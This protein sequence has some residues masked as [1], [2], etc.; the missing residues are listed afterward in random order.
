MPEWDSST[1]LSLR[2]LQGFGETSQSKLPDYMVPT[3][4]VTLDAFPL[5][6]NG[7]VNRRALP[8]PDS[9]RPD[10]DIQYIAPRTLT[11]ELL[12]KVWGEVLGVDEI[13]IHDSFFELGGHSLGAVQALVRIRATFGVEL[14]LQAFLRSS[15]LARLAE[16]VE[17]QMSE[18]EK[19]P[20]ALSLPKI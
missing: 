18:Q 8:A 16:A 11:E 5:T 3:H 1:L 9:A 17:E 2:T 12:A 14:P 15:T 13:G 7:K 10:L 20:N 6:P 4:F 19:E